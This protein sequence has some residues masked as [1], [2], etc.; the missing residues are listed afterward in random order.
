MGKSYKHYTADNLRDALIACHAFS[1]E[2]GPS[3]AVPFKAIGDQHGGV[4]RETLR[5]RFFAELDKK[6]EPGSSVGIVKSG[7]FVLYRDT[8]QKL[9][10]WVRESTTA[11]LTPTA[12]TLKYKA[13]KLLRLQNIAKREQRV[14]VNKAA[15]DANVPTNRWVGRFCRRTGLSL[16]KVGGV[17]FKRHAANV[18]TAGMLSWWPQY[19]E[20]LDL[21]CVIDPLTGEAL[22][23][24]RDCPGRIFNADESGF[25]RQTSY[26]EKGIA[27]KGSTVPLRPVDDDKESCTVFAWGSATGEVKPLKFIFKGTFAGQNYMQ[28]CRKNVSFILKRKTHFIDGEILR[29]LIKSMSSDV[30]GGISPWAFPYQQVGRVG[31]G[32][33]RWK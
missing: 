7:K 11:N 17:S 26:N 21:P 15:N 23:T 18:D 12:L 9:A 31:G 5:G 32:L 19:E 30:D 20:V 33:R 8:E 1:A 16:R 27:P 28:H 2:K 22:R 24:F 25:Q 10:Q 3:A 4:P 13:L 6:L 14:F 29:L